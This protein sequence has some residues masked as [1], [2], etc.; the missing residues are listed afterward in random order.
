MNQSKYEEI[1]QH[2]IDY[3][4]NLPSKSEI[5]V[6]AAIIDKNLEIVS[7]SI[8]LITTD[9]DPTAHAEIVAIRQAA[10]KLQNNRLDSYSLIS[11]LEPC[12]MCSGAISQ[13]RINKVIFGAYEPKTGFVSSLFPTIKE[14]QPKLEVLGGVLEDKCSKILTN[15]FSLKR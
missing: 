13:A 1:M 6:A 8:N 2:L 7:K 15:W 4:T 12:L 10:K 9:L 11:T 5:P 14:F 3:L